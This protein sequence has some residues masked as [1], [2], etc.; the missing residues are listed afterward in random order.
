M[1]FFFFSSRRRHTRCALVTVVQTCA[2]PI[3]RKLFN[4]QGVL[5]RV[6]GPAVMDD[7]HVMWC[8][9]G[10]VT[11]KGGLPAL[12]HFDGSV[13]EWREDGLLHRDHDLPASVDRKSVV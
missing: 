13:T 9:N 6:D 5:H 2:L 7:K 4:E 12:I 11:R 8:E 10:K 3:L 1:L